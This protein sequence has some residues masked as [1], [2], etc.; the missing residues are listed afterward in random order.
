MASIDASEHEAPLVE[1]PAIWRSVPELAG[2]PGASEAAA[3]Q[4]D[5][6]QS[7]KADD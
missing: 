7:D 6:P 1:W 2:A 3:G 5:D 4:Q